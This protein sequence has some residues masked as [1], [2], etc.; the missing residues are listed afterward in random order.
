MDDYGALA[1]NTE[2]RKP[3]YQA[4]NFSQCTLSTKMPHWLP[5]MRGWEEK[6]IQGFDWEFESKDHL[7]ILDVIGKIILK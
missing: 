2:R 1:N 6:N 3:K 7:E 5:G 4:K